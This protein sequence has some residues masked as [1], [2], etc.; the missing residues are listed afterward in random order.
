MSELGSVRLHVALREGFDLDTV[1][2]DVG[3]SHFAFA[4]LST[5]TQ[6]G[7]ADEVDVDLPIGSSEVRIAL[8]DRGLTAVTRYRLETETWLGVDLVGDAVE[9]TWSHDPFLYA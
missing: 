1:D 3:D 6:I 4:R 5:R 2:L 9:F 8:A 7:L